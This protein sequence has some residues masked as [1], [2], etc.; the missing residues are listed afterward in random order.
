MIGLLGTYIIFYGDREKKVIQQYQDKITRRLVD[1]QKKG[2]K[3]DKFNILLSALSE[4]EQKVM[5]AVR[6]QDGITQA[7]LRIRTDLSK[8]KLSFILADLEKKDLIKKV[9]QGKTNAI[10]LKKPI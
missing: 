2:L 1:V 5:K 8:T 10:Y 7:T 3:E 6:E 4:D 9:A